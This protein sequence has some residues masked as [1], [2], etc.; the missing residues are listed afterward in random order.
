[1]TDLQARYVKHLRAQAKTAET[2]PPPDTLLCPYCPEGRIF[3]AEGQLWDH[4]ALEHA[5]HLSS[6]GDPSHART[7]L[8]EEGLRRS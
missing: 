4:A 5:H 8:R 1:M 2:S 6:L 3:Q 7:L